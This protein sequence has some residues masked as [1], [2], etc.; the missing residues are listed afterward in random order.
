MNIF[1]SFCTNC[2][3]LIYIDIILECRLEEPVIEFPPLKVKDLPVIKSTNPD[4]FYEE[5]SR[6]VS[7]CKVSSG[8]IWNTFEDLEQSTLDTLSQQLSIPMFPIGP[9]HKYN[10]AYSSSSLLTEEQS[11]IS[12]LNTQRQKSVIYVSFG[13]VAILSEAEFLEIAWGLAN[14]EQPFLWVVRPGLVHGSKWLEALPNGFL[15]NLGG[16][17]HIVKWAPQQK[18]LAHWAVGA[19]WTHSGWNSTMESI[20]EGVPMICRPSFIDQKVNAKYVSHVWKVG[21]QLENENL[22]RGEIERSIR[23]LIKEKEGEEIRCRAS[24]LK[25]K[26]I[27]CSEPGGSSYKSLDRLL[28]HILSL[29]TITFHTQN[30]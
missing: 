11:S 9:F 26:A 14:S 12:W 17:G 10:L 25:D 20:C 1:C 8:L 18:V 5:I 19:F 30:Q 13:S 7:E 16:R 6:V 2:H 24:K 3:D 23:K 15:E 22:E 21:V 28:N 27:S 29:E 4:E